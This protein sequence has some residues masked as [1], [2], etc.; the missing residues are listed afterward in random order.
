MDDLQPE[1]VTATKQPGTQMVTGVSANKTK[2][3]KPATRP[4]PAKQK[5]DGAIFPAH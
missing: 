1:D 4:K 5:L 3:Q 2:P